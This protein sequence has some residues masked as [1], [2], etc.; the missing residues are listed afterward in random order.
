MPPQP[1]TVKCVI[2]GDAA[3]GKTSLLTTYSEGHFPKEYVPTGNFSF[4]NYRCKL[5]YKLKL[6]GYNIPF[7]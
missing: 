3:V 4:Y 7:Y 1:K 5:T 2:V 6:I